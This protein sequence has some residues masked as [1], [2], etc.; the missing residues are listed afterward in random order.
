[1][2]FKSIYSDARDYGYLNPTEGITFYSLLEHLQLSYDLSDNFLLH[3][4]D[5]FL[6][7]FKSTTPQND[8][9][10][11]R[12]FKLELTNYDYNRSWLEQLKTK[13]FYLKGDAEKKHIDYLELRQARRSSNRAFK[14]S[15][16]AII[17]S[18]ITGFGTTWYTNE[19]TPEYPTEIRLN[20]EQNEAIL[21]SLERLNQ[22]LDREK[23]DSLI[24]EIRELSRQ[25]NERNKVTP[26]KKS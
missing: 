9:D 15:I 23:N 4:A 17:I 12:A 2:D 18:I 7:N 26:N 16:G 25:L 22:K 21:E 11:I 19:N 20:S 6:E 10:R 24:R 3:F 14:L 8:G 5:W 1:M 13:R